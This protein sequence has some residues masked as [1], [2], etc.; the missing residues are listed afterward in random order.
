MLRAR[1][2]SA[3]AP[4]VS[5]DLHFADSGVRSGETGQSGR[6]CSRGHKEAGCIWRSFSRLLKLLEDAGASRPDGGERPCRDMD[7]ESRPAPEKEKDGGSF[8]ELLRD[9]IRI[10]FLCPTAADHYVA[11][12]YR[13]MRTEQYKRACF[14][15]TLGHSFFCCPLLFLNI[16]PLIS[17]RSS[18][19]PGYR[20]PQLPE[21]RRP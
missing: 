10:P 9:G 11:V 20:I 18:S 1:A 14:T 19:L 2:C 4:L 6:D 12:P 21:A 13:H 5:C 8:L 7:V 3:P 17:S 15:Q 16:A